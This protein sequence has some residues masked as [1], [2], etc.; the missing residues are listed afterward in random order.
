MCISTSGSDLF[1]GYSQ[2]IYPWN[3]Y[4]HPLCIIHQTPTW[5]P[6]KS[7]DHTLDLIHPLNTLH[8]SYSTPFVCSGFCACGPDLVQAGDPWHLSK[9]EPNDPLKK[10]GH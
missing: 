2:F 3:S 1:T 4:Y 7:I 10:V 8:L 9:L 6:L 5:H